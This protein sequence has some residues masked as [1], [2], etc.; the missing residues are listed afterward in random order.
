MCFF[1][2]ALTILYNVK[3]EKRIENEMKMKYP[4]EVEGSADEI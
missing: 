1:D 4:P 3:A 2:K